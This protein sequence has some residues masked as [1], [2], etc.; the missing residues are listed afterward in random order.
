LFNQKIIINFD[1]LNVLKRYT[2]FKQSYEK[3]KNYLLILFILSNVLIFGQN[4]SS[5]F[6]I[7]LGIGYKISKKIAL[8]F[9]NFSGL[10]K[11]DD[12]VKSYIF[13]FGVEYE[14]E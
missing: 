4:R 2:Q 6:G 10:I 9:R 5:S 12:N 14:L 7:S 13:N 11:R 3:N 8:N 1:K